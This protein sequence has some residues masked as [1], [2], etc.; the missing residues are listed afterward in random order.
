MQDRQATVAFWTLLVGVHAAFFAFQLVHHDPY[1]SD[2]FE[3]LAVAGNIAEEAIFYAGDLAEPL[4]P[5]L[6]T[7]RPPL[8]PLLLAATGAH[9][10][11]FVVTL[12]LQNLLSLFNLYLVLGLLGRI[13]GRERSART[14]LLPALLL[15]LLYPSQLIYANMIMSEMMLQ[16]LI[17]AAF[18]G[19]ARYVLGDGDRYLLLYSVLLAAAALTKPVMYLFVIPNAVLMLAAGLRRRDVRPMVYSLLPIVV[20]VG[21][22]AWNA[23]RTGLFHFSS[24]QSASL[25]DYNTRYL[26]IQTEG[27][28][29]A[30]ALVEDVHRRAARAGSFAERQGILHAG[31]WELLRPRLFSY[32]AFHLR[33]TLAFFLDPGRF[34]LYHFFGIPSG[35][36]GL[37]YH[38]SQ[39]GLSGIWTYLSTQPL[40]MVAAWVLI[41]VANA[42]RLV[43]LLVSAIARIQAEVKWGLLLLIGYV[44]VVTGPVGAARFAVPV[45]PLI[46]LA[47]LF[48]LDHLKSLPARSRRRIETS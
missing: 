24:I 2:S 27:P 10:G 44:A 46:V 45:F 47:V 14:V 34:D 48:T 26:L 4:D 38:F 17:T 15:V 18:Y 30:T 43:G 13:T 7:K 39:S 37:L 40:A 35:G 12:L 41:A 36:N 5:A 19:F 28:D 9:T 23:Y 3:Y 32:V 42:V 33:G 21:Y 1:L 16:T 22:C 8:Y 31:A 29:A 20:I 11:L 25:L 6:F